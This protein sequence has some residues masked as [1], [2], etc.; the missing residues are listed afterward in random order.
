MPIEEKPRALE[1][2]FISENDSSSRYEITYDSEKDIDPVMIKWKSVTL[3]VPVELF[4]EVV[5]FLKQKGVLKGKNNPPSGGSNVKRTKTIPLPVI[6]G[7]EEDAEETMIQTNPI[8]SFDS[9]VEQEDILKEIVEKD[10]P[11]EENIIKE[12]KK[13]DTIPKRKV[14]KTRIQDDGDPLQ[15]EREAAE[16]RGKKESKIK[17]K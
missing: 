16:L 5:D 2:T 12:E 14:I 4:V 9:S 6:D 3:N 17:R 8:T 7:Q 1:F 11:K 15:A 13:D 10:I